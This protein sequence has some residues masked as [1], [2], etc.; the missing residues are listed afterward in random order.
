M[1]PTVT[2]TN[3]DVR[4]YSAGV[5][6]VDFSRYPSIKAEWPTLRKSIARVATTTHYEFSISMVIL[7][8]LMMVCYETDLDADPDSEKPPWLRP[9]ALVIL[10]FYLAELALRVYAFRWD[11]FASKSNLVDVFTLVLDVFLEITENLV[12]AP[13]PTGLRVTRVLRA[14]RFVRAVRT[15]MMFRELYMMLHGFVSALRALLWAMV[16]LGVM[17]TMWSVLAVEILHPLNLEVAETG[18]YEGCERCPRAFESVMSSNIT[19][20]QQ[21]I[22]GDSWGLVSIPIIEKYPWSGVLIFCVMVTIDLGLLNLI[23]TVIVDRAQAAH[24][25]DTKFLMQQRMEHYEVAKRKLHKLCC[26]MDTD[27]S[28]SLSLEELMDGFDNLPEFQDTMRL[29]DVAREDLASLFQV[30]DEDMSGAVDYEEFVEQL[31]K[32]KCQDKNMLLVFLRSDLKKVKDH[33]KDTSKRVDRL[34]TKLDSKNLNGGVYMDQPNVQVAAVPRPCTKDY[35]NGNHDYTNGNHELLEPKVP[36]TLEPKAPM[37]E[38]KEFPQI[39]QLALQ[40]SPEL[41]SDL[42]KHIAVDTQS[43]DS[44]TWRTPSAGIPTEETAIYIRTPISSHSHS[45]ERWQHRS[46]PLGLQSNGGS[47]AYG[48]GA[49]LDRAR[50]MRLQASEDNER[51]LLRFDGRLPAR[52]VVVAQADAVNSTELSQSSWSQAQANVEDFPARRA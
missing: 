36:F 40:T 51:L 33:T 27:D 30:L 35:T 7:V 43:D 6:W 31:H 4:D 22:A 28:G 25:E 1:Q 10:M 5:F 11:F 38:F 18:V 2:L 14:V 47:A 20:M 21:I 3:G 39:Q 23:L 9:T 34:L 12:K 26:A 32:L 29:M 13:S 46:K 19:F 48:P 24:Q 45:P 44:A 50:S 16:I 37:M 17:L 8:N 41:V 52:P 42:K 15:L 49:C